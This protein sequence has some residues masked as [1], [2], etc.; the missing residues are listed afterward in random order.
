[1][2]S[3]RG[4]IKDPTESSEDMEDMDSNTRRSAIRN[5]HRV[6]EKLGASCCGCACID[7]I[8]VRSLRHEIQTKESK[9]RKTSQSLR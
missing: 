2:S 4:D 6:K 1:M 3:S 9:T 8:G 5:T 7:I